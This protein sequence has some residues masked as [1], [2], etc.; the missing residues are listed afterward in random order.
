MIHV[1]KEN[2]KLEDIARNY[3]IS[4]SSILNANR[5]IAMVANRAIWIPVSKDKRPAMGFDIG[6]LP[7]ISLYAMHSPKNDLSRT[8]EGLQ[9]RAKGVFIDSIFAERNC[10][11]M[12]D[13]FYPVCCS[14]Y[15]SAQPS[16]IMKGLGLF[17]KES[18]FNSLATGLKFKEYGG[19]LLCIETTDDLMHYEKARDWL[20]GYGLDVYVCADS[21]TLLSI[22]PSS[23]V[24][25]FFYKPNTS[26]FSFST[27]KSELGLLSKIFKPESLGYA[28]SPGA[29]VINKNT[30]IAKYP[31]IRQVEKALTKDGISRVL[32][33]SSSKLCIAQ[34]KVNSELHNV[35]FEDL[36]SLESKLAYIREAG[37]GSLLIE[38]PIALI[39]AISAIAT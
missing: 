1:I 15:Y 13:D 7:E 20:Y 10:I 2:E 24:E 25:Y 6:S 36:R 33:D 29:A 4:A 19:V 37:I 34:Y 23:R 26:S 30:N 9:R 27:F 39:P 32:Y 16:F 14:Q 18:N 28:L 38:S 21:A 5:S 3:G 17:M 8:L 11:R 35:V 31:D 12:F 22:G